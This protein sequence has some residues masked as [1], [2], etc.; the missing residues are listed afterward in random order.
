MK[1]IIHTLTEVNDLIRQFGDDDQTNT[2]RHFR[3]GLL[4]FV[5]EISHSLFG[6]TRDSDISKMH[7]SMRDYERNQASLSAAW[8]Q[9][10][11]RL[12][13]LSKSINNRLDYMKNMIDLQRQTVTELYAQ[14]REE[15]SAL[16]HAS[17]LIGLALARFEQYP[18]LLDNIDAFRLGIELLSNGF[19]SPELI[20]LIELRNVLDHINRKVGVL[21]VDG[22]HVLRKE[23]LHYY[24][25]HEFMATRSGRNIIVYLPIP[26]GP[27]RHTFALYEVHVMLLPVPDSNHATTLIQVPQYIGYNPDSDY[28]LQFD[29]KPSITISKLLFLDHTH[30][31]LQSVSANSCILSL[32]RDNSTNIHKNCQFAVLTHSIHPDVFVLDSKHVM[33]TNVKHAFI[34]CSGVGSRNVTCLD[35]CRVTVPCGCSL[36]S[37]FFYLHS[38]IENCR[39]TRRGRK[40]LHA[41]NLAF[42]HNLFEASQLAD[43]SRTSLFD[44]PLKIITP[45]LK[46]LEANYSHELKVDKQARLDLIK[47]ANLTK[48]DE[49]AYP[50]SA[51]S[52]VDSWQDYSSGSYDWF[53]S[54]FSWRS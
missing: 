35:S 37:D 27:L 51:H 6:T 17:S 23:A 47:L 43:L 7:A 11:S 25:M 18:L 20:R 4:N 39:S 34:N 53:F 50:S 54:L 14:L 32:L 30:S 12:A 36:K 3:R 40:V 46:I 15:T 10:G 16:D 48:Q 22:Q 29:T 9:M 19:L 28:F 41:V 2:S 49:Q 31:F 5:G 24:R 45:K 21:T 1:R 8:R 44:N 26:L 38:R 33:L 42:L 52:M 13:S